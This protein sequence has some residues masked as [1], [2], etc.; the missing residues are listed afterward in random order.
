M[1]SFC[2]LCLFAVFC[3]QTPLQ[4]SGQEPECAICV[5]VSGWGY[6]D[7]EYGGRTDCV[8]VVRIDLEGGVELDCE[9]TWEGEDC[10]EVVVMNLGVSPS[11]VVPMNPSGTPAFEEL[12]TDLPPCG[13]IF[14]GYYADE[15]E[16]LS[17]THLRI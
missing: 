15:E 12:R 9:H 1:R 16:V 10:D 14:R 5:G 8:P 6:C 17:P 4:L 3:F 13:L 2:N 11:G 7:G